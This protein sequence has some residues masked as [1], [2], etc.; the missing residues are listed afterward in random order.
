M[1]VNADCIAWSPII[2]LQG[3]PALR[4]TI[5]KNLAKQTLPR[6]ELCAAV[7]GADLA[8]RIQGDLRIRIDNVQYWTD[9][10]IVLGW[11]IATASHVHGKPNCSDSRTNKSGAMGACIIGS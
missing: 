4:S 9:S 2:T 8:G 7:L 11:I 5:E 3:H 1:T 6:L 10:T